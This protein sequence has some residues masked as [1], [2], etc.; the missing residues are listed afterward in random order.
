MHASDVARRMEEREL[1]ATSLSA[2]TRYRKYVQQVEKCLATFESVHEWADFIAFLTK[3]L[4]TLQSFNQYKEVPHKLMLSKRLAQCLNPA[5]PTGVHQRALDVYSHILTLIGPEGLKRDLLIWSPGLLPFFEYAATSVKPALLN[6]YTTHYL[7]LKSSL[8]PI[9]KSLVLGILPGLEEETG[10]FFDG[11]IVILDDLSNSI[12]LAFFLQN[13][14]LILLTAPAIRPAVLNYLSRRFPKLDHRDG[15]ES[16]VGNDIG[17]MIRAFGV[18]LEDNNIL[19]RRGVLELL[20]KSFRLDTP[21]LVAKEHKDNKI[22]LM[23]AALGVVLR[24]DLSLNRRLFSWLLGPDEHSDAQMKYFQEYGLE[25]LASALKEDMFSEPPGVLDSRP[26]R[27]FIYLLDKW[28]IGSLLTEVFVLEAFQAVCTAVQDLSK[29]GSDERLADL[30]MTA[31]TLYEAVEPFALW[32]QLFISTME[33]LS[34]NRL[35]GKSMRVVLFMLKSFPLRDEEVLRIHLPLL[36]MATS[37]ALTTLISDDILTLGRLEPF[38][39]GMELLQLLLRHIPS[40]VLSQPLQLS[41]NDHGENMHLSAFSRALAFYGIEGTNW[42]SSR[43]PSASEHSLSPFA[44]CL[45]HALL[46]SEASVQSITLSEMGQVAFDSFAVIA[47]LITVLVSRLEEKL[48]CEL[49]LDWWD[50]QRWSGMALRVVDGAPS[51]DTLQKVIV[52]TITLS[53]SQHLHP[54]LLINDRRLLEKITLALMRFLR[55]QYVPYHIPA[56]Q[57]IWTLERSTRNHHIE[58]IIASSLSITN[59]QPLHSTETFEA[60]G[61]FWRLTDDS[62]VPGHTFRQPLFLILDALRNDNPT[63]RRLAETW[64]RCNLK[65]YL[66]VVEPILFDLLDPTAQRI[67]ITNSHQN[68]TIRAY[69]YKRPVD[70][71]VARH[72]VESLQTVARFGGQGFGR[73]LRTTPME[74]SLYPG[75]ISRIP[76]DCIPQSCN[77]MD[78]LIDI[79]LGFLQ[80]EPHPDNAALMGPNNTRLQ[81][82]SLDLLQFLASQGDLQSAAL[83]SI[84]EA[85]VGKLYSVVHNDR[86]DLQPKLLHVLHSVTVASVASTRHV[87]PPLGYETG[88]ELDLG[89]GSDKQLRESMQPFASVGMHPLLLQTIVDGISSEDNRPILQHW[90]DFI[91]MTLPLLQHSATAIIYQLN[92][93][94]SRLLRTAINKL[95]DTPGKTKTQRDV[96]LFVTDSELIALLNALERVVLLGVA[97]SQQDSRQ[98]E[99]LVHSEKTAGESTGLLGL[100]SNVFVAD[101]SGAPDDGL[102]PR[103]PSY[104][105]LHEAIRVLAFIWLKTSLTTSEESTVIKESLSLIFT[106]VKARCRKVLENLFRSY[107]IEVLETIIASWESDEVMILTRDDR[108]NSTLEIIDVLASSAQTAVHF[109]CESLSNR[110]LYPERG[111]RAIVGMNLSEMVLFEFLEEYLARL[112]GPVAFQV[113]GRYLALAKEIATNV[114]SYKSHVLPVL[115]CLTVLSDKVTQTSA[116]EDRRFRRDLQDIFVKLVDACILISGKSFESSNWIRR[117]AKDG[118]GETRSSTPVARVTQSEVVPSDKVDA[119]GIIPADEAGKRTSGLELTDQINA[120]LASSIIL[121]M[122]RFITESDKIVG[123]CNNLTYYI[124]GPAMKSKSRTIEMDP[125]V[126]RILSEM[127]KIPIAIKAWKN[128]LVELFNDNRFFNGPPEMAHKWRPL[129]RSLIEA[130]KQVVTELLGKLASTP[131]ANIFTNR[132][133]ETLL[134]SLNLRRL[135]FILFAGDKDQFLVQLPAIQE[136]LVDTLRTSSGVPAVVSEI[137]LCLR[138][139]LCRLSSRNMLSFWPVILTEMIR[140]F[141]NI[142]SSPPPDG[143]DE[144]AIVLAA[145][146]FLDLILVLQPEDFQVH[147]WI[148]V[149]DT[150]DAIYRPDNWVPESI[151]DQLAEVI[152]GPSNAQS[153]VRPHVRTIPVSI[154]AGEPKLAQSSDLDESH[155]N[156]IH[157]LRQ[158]TLGALHSINSIT[159]LTPFVSSIS[160]ATYENIYRSALRTPG[161]GVEGVNWAIVEQILAEEM[162]EGS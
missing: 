117:T 22:L 49:H 7:P 71:V 33:G 139:L 73:A 12:G 76:A 150:V 28:E 78:V 6:I 102:T 14:W 153:V 24:K 67:P 123:I 126:L 70:L 156:R 106:R 80:T 54:R 58:S 30:M 155:N 45:R 44:A 136:R 121:N 161:S 105:C 47:A 59:D 148:F 84:G 127:A 64:M 143:S 34:D 16:I 133:Y 46:V 152:G 60:F 77:F 120:F 115:R 4:K 82:L 13:I 111:K 145:C 154:H 95:A 19:V 100:V 118:H 146:K 98:E 125:N 9:M 1:A 21:L 25:T 122:R 56:V 113:W 55:P 48:Q 32:K 8:R 53:K 157:S 79:L 3:L 86:L 91:L 96:T 87:L 108:L 39:L 158:P 63:L 94:I 141:N 43:L 36:L 93:T 159:E 42:K 65:S 101:S 35:L 103:S 142:R 132:E 29:S 83:D 116:T 89:V 124:V 31:N 130:D 110:I 119:F 129:I 41:E 5:L 52:A 109:I 151:M 85:V 2:D 138:V 18:S 160:I 40:N 149:T 162:F 69:M 75:L 10:E 131:A 99:E 104:R 114:H 72:L 23:R 97:H 61:I 11:V 128:P 135:S 20:V 147:Q 137:Y 17:L 92:D 81:A 107:S 37:E 66:R 38:Q 90:V 144:L 26:F 57:L 74:K 50:P 134:R 27:I 88:R 51:F 15:M 68:T 140:T 62:L 112:E